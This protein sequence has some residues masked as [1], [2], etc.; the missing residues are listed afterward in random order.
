M[1]YIV[2]AL[3]LLV[4]SILYIKIAERYDIVDKPNHRS[5][6][7]EP[8]IRGA[9]LIFYLAILIFFIF[10]GFKMSYFMIGLTIISLIS[11]IDDLIS[12]SS[13]IRLV[14]Q[15]ISIGLIMYQL[16]LFTDIYWG[17]IPILLTFG[18]GFIN[19]FN[20]MDGINGMTGIYSLLAFLSLY[21]INIYENL[22]D[23]QLL[24][25]IIISILIFGF[26]NFR[27]QAR[28]FCGDI[29]S[30]CLAVT[31][32]FLLSFFTIKLKSPL[33]IL[34]MGVYLTDA[35]LT[36][37][38]RKFLGENVTVAHR[39]HIYQKLTD[40]LNYSHIKVSLM[41]GLL[42]FAIFLIILN[43]YKQSLVIQSIVFF[44]I[45][46]ILLLVYIALFRLLKNQ[47]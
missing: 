44:V 31:L 43:T 24:I 28:F 37:I 26:F 13:R 32:F 4:F 22:I 42:Q 25:F 10:S 14:F 33:F 23:G 27:K 2:V 35:G 47:N 36:I 46:L 8:I 11:Y 9:G 45:S 39:H 16:I 18:V 21:I 15:F 1:E 5:S 40:V 41:Y 29:G 19:I 6:H 7:T 12:L 20:F 38:Y 30:I 17:I 3:V 34:L